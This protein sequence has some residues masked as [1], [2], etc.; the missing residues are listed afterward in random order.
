MVMKR[1]FIF[2]V[3]LLIVSM[4]LMGKKLA[5]IPEVFQPFLLVMDDQQ[6]YVTEGATVSIFSRKDYTMK[7]KFGK[8]GEGPQEFKLAQGMPGLILYPHTDSLVINSAGKV[9]FYTKDGKFIKELKVPTGSMVSIFQQAYEFIKNMITFADYYP[10][11]QGIYIDNQKIYIQTYMKKDEEYEFFIYE[12]NGKFL[13]R[14]FLPVKYMNGFMP[15]P[16]AIKDNIL[17]QLV[18]NEEDESWELHAHPIK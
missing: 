10:A 2:F 12:V 11:L 16:T 9:S 13:Q 5:T 15:N 7:T 1:W 4:G 18:E 17:Y 14:L 3:V 6:F 8:E